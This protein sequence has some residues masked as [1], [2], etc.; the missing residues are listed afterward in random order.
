VTAAHLL[1]LYKSSWL[2]FVIQ[3][4]GWGL[5]THTCVFVITPRASASG[6]AISFVC[7]SVCHHQNARSGDVG[8]RATGKHNESIEVGKKLASV[9][10]K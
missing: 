10:F 8:I 3:Y 4:R 2:A 1:I 5:F 9:C 6:K 7:V